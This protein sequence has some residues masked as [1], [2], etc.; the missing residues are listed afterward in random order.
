M[1]R[2]P[3]RVKPDHELVKVQLRT[4]GVDARA[5]DAEARPRDCFSRADGKLVGFFGHWACGPENHDYRCGTRTVR[6]GDC[7]TMAKDPKNPVPGDLAIDCSPI[8]DLII[9]LPPGAMV[10]MRREHEGL[11]ALLTEVSA[12]QK[13]SG[14]RAGILDADAQA[15]AKLTEKIL[16]VRKYK[17]P[18]RKLL[19]LVTETEASLDHERHQ[20][21][22]NIASSVEQ[23]AKMP[24]NEDLRSLYRSTREYRSAIS[25]KAAKTRSKSKPTEPAPAPAP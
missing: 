20:H 10:G 15:L 13:S 19:E 17:E 16:L 2:E 25:K 22:S 3:E 4:R 9:D 14:A 7:V 5:R 1:K 21:I 8:A 24:G 18:L 12:N 6:G 11:D 23:R